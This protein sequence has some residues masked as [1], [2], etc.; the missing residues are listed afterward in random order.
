M[1][2]REVLQNEATGVRDGMILAGAA[3][4]ALLIDAMSIIV[5]PMSPVVRGCAEHV[6]R[7]R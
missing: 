5:R 3:E 1:P 6:R 7:S 4:K 2:Q